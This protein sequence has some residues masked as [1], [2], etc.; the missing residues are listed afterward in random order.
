MAISGNASAAVPAE[1][2][3]A[4][5]GAGFS[6][7]YMLYR[8]RELGFSAVALDEAGDVGGTWYWNRYP[9]ARCDVPTTDYAY[10][11]DPQLEKDWT[12]SE[13]YATQPEILAYLQ[14]VADRYDLRRDIR[15]ASGSL[16]PAG[17]RPAGAGGCAL[18]TATRS[19][20]GT[21]SWP[22][23]ACPCRKLPTSRASIAT[24]ATSTSRAGGPMT[25]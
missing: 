6:G 9:G 13:K 24:E 2:D 16:L 25:G 12:W 20:A 1:V 18:A 8:L 21:T 3:A 15:S 7:L 17:T 10:S 11:F 5:I 22:A 14:H 4:V 19:A 23:G